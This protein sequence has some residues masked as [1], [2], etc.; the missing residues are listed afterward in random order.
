MTAA[1]PFFMDFQFSVSTAEGFCFLKDCALVVCKVIF[2]SCC[3]FLVGRSFQR[4]ILWVRPSLAPIR[5]PVQTPPFL[6]MNEQEM[7]MLRIMYHMSWAPR[8]AMG[9]HVSICA[10]Q[11]PPPKVPKGPDGHIWGEIIFS[12]GSFFGFPL[13]TFMTVIRAVKYFLIHKGFEKLG[14]N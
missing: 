1:L 8:T 6:I 2:N 10:C 11:I 14:Q 9:V 4:K 13:S 7:S 5:S 3:R 12:E